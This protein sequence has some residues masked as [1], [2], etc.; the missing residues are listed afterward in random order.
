M[1]F[2]TEQTLEIE[3]RIKG[4]GYAEY[5][6]M[7]RIKAQEK[8]E[9]ERNGRQRAR[10]DRGEWFRPMPEKV[11]LGPGIKVLPTLP[12]MRY[13]HT[14]P[15]CG[16]H[17]VSKIGGSLTEGWESVLCKNCDYGWDVHL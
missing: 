12:W 7:L 13:I 3:Q 1:M 8:R 6:A 11:D 5:L 16:C 2:R 14:C 4:N 10:A 15:R 17:A 9:E